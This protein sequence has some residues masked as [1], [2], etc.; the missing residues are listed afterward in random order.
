MAISYTLVTG[1][2]QGIDLE[3]AQGLG[4][5]GFTL[6]LG[7]RSLFKAQEAAKAI[8]EE[9]SVEAE[10]VSLDVRSDES[11]AA[12]RETIEK[13]CAETGGSFHLLINNAAIAGDPS[14]PIRENYAAILDTNVSSVAVMMDTFI[15]LLQRSQ[16]KLGD[17][18]SMS[19]QL[20]GR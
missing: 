8:A 13:L 2:N 11:I 4:E 16:H 3:I 18:S 12:A 9:S 7:C 10:I 15:P 1:A 14:K 20:E 17:I 6:I 5:I 19:H